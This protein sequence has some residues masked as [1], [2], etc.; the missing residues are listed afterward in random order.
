[1]G[2]GPVLFAVVE[3]VEARIRRLSYNQLKALS[4]LCQ[5]ELGLASSSVAG[6]KIGITGKALG[7]IFSSLSRQKIAGQPLLIPVGRDA[8]GRGLRW[9][10]NTKLISVKRLREITTELL[11]L[12]EQ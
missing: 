3:K 4:V 6:K 10:L 8:A 5:N 2:L 1:M 12:W 11:R 7:G 9:R